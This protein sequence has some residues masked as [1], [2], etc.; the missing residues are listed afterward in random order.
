M[1]FILD[2]LKK[3]ESERQRQNAPGIADL[4]QAAARQSSRGWLWIV[5][6]LLTI[7]LVVLFGLMLRPGQRADAPS[8]TSAAAPADIMKE[9]DAG[10]ETLNDLPVVVPQVS[11]ATQQSEDS[12]ST[13]LPAQSEVIADS[14][15][16]T[17][18]AVVARATIAD[19]PQTLNELRAR[20]VLQ[21]GEL[22][23]DIHV[24]STDPADRFV[25]INMSKY[26]ETAALAEGP[27]VREITPD[28][29]IL[30]HQGT[31]FLLP[32]E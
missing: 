8:V 24:Y 2:A 13:G 10:V 28:G 15:P 32:R 21:L 16:Q 5:G 1:S 7:N 26:K 3:S 11:A 6:V 31:E 12:A 23:L 27:V 19:G 22:H 30:E 14:A 17:G 4:P 25:F 9:T 29:V 20:G 18:P